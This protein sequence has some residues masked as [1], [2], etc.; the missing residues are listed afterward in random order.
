MIFHKN[1]SEIKENKID[2]NGARE[3]Q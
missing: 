3:F 2:A 1:I